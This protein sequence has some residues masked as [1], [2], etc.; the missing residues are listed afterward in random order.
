MSN[1]LIV[2]TA[3]AL[4]SGSLLTGTA[5]R[6]ALAAGVLDL[7]DARRK[8]HGV[9]TPVMGGPAIF[10]SLAATVAAATFLPGPAA[11]LAAVPGRMLAMLLVSGGLFCLLGFYDDVRPM[12][13]SRKFLWQFVA[14][15]PFA[16][17]GA[18]VTWIE[19]C[20][21]DVTL[22]GTVGTALTLF[23]LV[24]CANTI[25]LIDGL[26]GL[27]GS[28][29]LIAC[30]GIAAVADLQNLPGATALALI[31]AGSLSGFLCHNLPPARIFLGDSGSLLI[32]FLIGA[33][34]IAST[35]KTATGFAMTVPL[36][37]VS[38][39][40]FDT[41]MAIA[42]RRLT[43]RGI[44][45]G[46]RGHIHHRLQDRGLTRTQTL[47]VIAGLCTAM[48]TLTVLSV[49]LKADVLCFVLCLGVLGL[50]ILGRVFGHQETLLL[51][52]RVQRVG[53]LI[54]EGSGAFGPARPASEPVPSWSEMIEQVRALG[55]TRLDLLR[56][57]ERTAA[58]LDRR[59]WSAETPAAVWELRVTSRA[60]GGQRLLL[61]AFGDRRLTASAA[62]PAGVF[63]LL[64]A[65]CRRWAASGLPVDPS[66]P[67]VVRFPAHQSPA[68][69][70]AEAVRKAA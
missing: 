29:G 11:L 60:A 23:W 17:F 70:A 26:D 35:L 46:D 32:G 44:G 59:N 16:A 58:E 43:G 33:L 9:P 21:V 55:V 24:A 5:R 63:L 41:F 61:T 20:G 7:P 36:I 14:A 51:L 13:A 18:P 45:E 15:F 3:L 67:D 66:V 34:A 53:R 56:W 40:A 50:L 8:L 48:T 62:G 57:D 49:S 42:R 25:N 4:I 28:V 65:C 68:S 10:L 37:L 2:I 69:P 22:G 1:D 31:V 64:D 19:I 54:V 52:R 27:A 38:V 12:R 47:A 6:V 39:P 30:V